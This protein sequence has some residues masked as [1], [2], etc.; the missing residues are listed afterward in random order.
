MP[1]AT[2]PSV[3]APDSP[4]PQFDAVVVGGGPAGL[5]AALALARTGQRVAIAAPPHRPAGDRPD[6]RTAA[7]FPGSIAMLANLGCWDE[8]R[9]QC[10]PL[11]AIRI[12]DD[13]EA[14]LRAPEVTFRGQEIGRPDFGYN[15]PN[16]PLV[17]ALL[18]R[19]REPA[20]GITMID[21]GGV[22]SLDIRDSDVRITLAEGPTVT[23]RLVAGADGRKSLCRH[24]A[25]IDTDSW[26]YDQCAITT[27]FHHSRP[28]DGI[29]T[30]F[31][32]PAGPC[33]T[34]PLP[35]NRSSLVW[36]ERP[37]VAEHLARADEAEFRRALEKRLH[38][39]LG[40]IGELSPRVV[41]PLSGLS[42]RTFAK[43]RVALIGEA[44]HVIPPIGAQGLNLGLRDGAALAD[45]V[46][47]AL[48]VGRDIGGPET[49]AAYD[50]AR[51]A[52]VTSRSW[53]IDLLNKSLLSQFLPVHI[54]RGA[55]LFA[56]KT[57]SP[58]RRLVV[59]EG[60]QPSFAEPSLMRA[61][62]H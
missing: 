36:V 41:F 34:V 5:A 30:E 17:D 62:T 51:R 44:G 14:L 40:T 35:G 28:H 20:S 18:K 58:L 42:A 53:T 39:L 16:T 19:C 27:I 22:E 32:R 3:P 45:C 29:S 49:L 15:V 6:M 26:R 60:L 11:A 10:A 55:G 12:I 31:H 57:L 46:T 50:R 61:S 4:A 8:L 37:D 33:T 43:N 52:D 21:T 9:P 38:G 2:A 25:G 13:R 47:E 59:R 7:L 23:S 54:A 56:L 1:A 48:G 24:A